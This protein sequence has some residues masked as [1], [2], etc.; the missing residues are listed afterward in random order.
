VERIVTV[1]GLMHATVLSR[2]KSLSYNLLSEISAHK[3]SF[4]AYIMLSTCNYVTNCIYCQ[5][6]VTRQVIVT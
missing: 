5:V 6:T 2:S 1:T 3:I 4:P